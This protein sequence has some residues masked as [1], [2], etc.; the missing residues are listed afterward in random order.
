MRSPQGDNKNAVARINTVEDELVEMV[1]REI[2][3]ASSEE[4]NVKGP[5]AESEKLILMPSLQE[6][7]PAVIPAITQEGAS[8][9]E[10]IDRL[11]S[12]LQETR[13]YF[14]REAERIAQAS[15]RFTQMSE[16]ASASLQIVSESIARWRREN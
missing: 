8:T 9:I 10:A 6:R 7:S 14:E 11:I 1:R 12:E 5:G 15:A 16:A 13:E 3:A 2:A 4:K